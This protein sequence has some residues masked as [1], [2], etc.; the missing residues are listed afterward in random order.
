MSSSAAKGKFWFDQKAADQMVKMPAR[1]SIWPHVLRKK[2]SIGSGCVCYTPNRD[3][4][5]G[6]GLIL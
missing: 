5:S 3:R 6:G 2:K 4:A 1:R